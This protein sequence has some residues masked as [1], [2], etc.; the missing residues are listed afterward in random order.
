MAVLVGK[1][2]PCGKDVARLIGLGRHLGEFGNIA[3]SR[4]IYD[5]A[6]R[7]GNLARFVLNKQR[8]DAVVFGGN[9]HNV[10]AVHNINVVFGQ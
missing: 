9:V 7:I 3:I 5:R 8:S 10:T 6:N 4:G 1:I 2:I